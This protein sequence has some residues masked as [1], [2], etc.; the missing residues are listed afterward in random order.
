MADYATLI[1]SIKE[2]LGCLD[3]PVITFGGSY[4]GMLST[5]MRLKYPSSVDGAVA[6]S[7]PVWSFVGEEPPV[8]PGAFAK[9]VTWD[10]TTAG[11]SPSS[12]APNVRLAWREMLR[13]RKRGDAAAIASIAA[14]LRICP[15]QPLATSEDVDAVMYWLQDAF[16]YLAMGN[17]PYPS[18]YILNGDGLLPSYPFRAA[19]SGQGRLLARHSCRI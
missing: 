17:Y 12:C 16:D 7:A 1:R 15:S 4:G 5:W 14:P 19:C 8:D 13:R 11:G 18:S 10:A 3:A 6:G 9:G 2:E